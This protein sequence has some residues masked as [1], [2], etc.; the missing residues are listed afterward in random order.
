MFLG[1]SMLFA[2][3][4]SGKAKGNKDK[5][6][7]VAVIEKNT[8][9]KGAASQSN[10]KYSKNQPSN[11]SAAFQRDYP[12]AKNVT[13][14]KYKGDWTA[15]FGNGIY[16]STAV[17]HANGQRRDTRTVINRN[18]LPGNGSVWDGIFKRN[19]V[20]ENNIIRIEQPQN[21]SLIYR[22]LT[23]TGSALFFNNQGETVKYK[24]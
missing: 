20:Q 7:N 18:D 16:R 22:V 9:R 24:Y 23:A 12:Y 4:N 15:T 11:V 10:G 21:N 8:D 13:W 1:I 5:K 17:Y 19:R 6:D 2:Q 14:S 3:G